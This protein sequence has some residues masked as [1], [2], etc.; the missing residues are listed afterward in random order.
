V[1]QEKP[2]QPPN[3]GNLKTAEWQQLQAQA[4]RLEAAWSTA[5]SVDLAP[6]VPPPGH[7][8]RLVFLHELIKTDLEIRWRRGRGRVL[9][10]YLRKF[11]ELG[12]AANLPASL[13]HEEFR[14][15]QRYDPKVQLTVYQL[16]FP[17]QFND[18]QRLVQQEAGQ[19]TPA[20]VV[21]TPTATPPG[22][23][24][25]SSNDQ[26]VPIGAGYKLVG[27]IGAGGFGEV[28]RAEAPGGFEV[29]LK[30]LFRTIEHEEA[31]REIQ[32]LELI[33]K[34]RHPF[35]LQTQAYWALQDRLYI[36]MELA[37]GSL[38]D[39]LREC[40]AQGLDGIPPDE[41]VQYMKESAEALDFLHARQVMHRDIKPENILLLQRH[42]KLCDFGLARL[43]QS[44]RLVSVT[45]SGTP[46]Y[47][48]PE[49]WANKVCP[50]SDQY[51]LAVTY[52]ELRL[53]RRLFASQ[54][55]VQLMSEVLTRTPSLEPLPQAEQEVLLK[56]MAKD[57]EQRYP[58][59]MAFAE[60]LE[61]AVVPNR[62]P[63]SGDVDLP[64]RQRTPSNEDWEA[65][66]LRSDEV[67]AA[68]SPT[69]PAT[70]S[71][72]PAW[73]TPPA[74]GVNPDRSPHATV[75]RLFWVLIFL[76]L[77][78]VPVL[79]IGQHMFPSGRDEEPSFRLDP[80]PDFPL[81]VGSRGTLT[82][83]I[84]RD[85]FSEPV[86]LTFEGMPATVK[87]HQARIPARGDLV[88][89][90]LSADL[91][92]EP[93]KYLIKVHARGGELKRE[94]AFTLTV[95]GPK[96]WWSDDWRLPAGARVVRDLDRQRL[97]DKIDVIRKV[98]GK[99]VAVRFVLVPRTRA[100]D[101]R[102][103]YIM[104]DKVSV[105]QFRAFATARPKE[106]KDDAWK[107]KDPKEMGNFPQ[108]NL[109]VMQVK[110]L[111]AY[112]F[113][114]WLGGELPSRQ[115][116]DK[117]AGWN[118]P[119]KRIGPFK[120]AWDPK[121]KDRPAVG[122]RG[123]GPLPCGAARQDV[124]PFGCQDMSGNGE[125]WTRDL[126]LFDGVMKDLLKEPETSEAFV[127]TRGRS[128]RAEKPL[129]FEKFDKIKAIRGWQSTRPDLGFRVLIQR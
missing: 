16:R 123:K 77:A 121:A 22:G 41:L 34:L 61:E 76:V 98:G 44:Q 10:F 60:A 23:V 51:C 125:E 109:P 122:R 96:D 116:W 56:A 55:L 53:N 50:Q 75:R 18:V 21:V 106:V 93:R 24:G 3:L 65:G 62:R 8:L 48:A 26:V 2:G 71:G 11:P 105:G 13:I 100:E 5:D 39:R 63:P 78:G 113:A 25:S 101:P 129:I 4:D 43:Q 84:R 20:A 95:E 64:R 83:V 128:W 70:P 112:R 99:V 45:G 59:C 124:S 30:I 14:L 46:A 107:K 66:T 54:N 92:A 35:L 28:Y 94:I 49:M 36:L 118:E 74:L 91:N 72:Q 104:Q 9:E 29:A 80:V 88:R 82:L 120:G 69:Q 127:F 110:V 12:P 42:A 57:P 58:T 7:P 6:F 73:H 108:D 111:D 17:G 102:S 19:K 31:K 86:E 119:G 38:R 68:L 15:R 85:H 97:Y 40:R 103:F 79:L 52:G 27:R 90:E 117:A 114:R 126:S 1:S 81:E 32:A 115:Q 89:V 33:R 47:M 37:D 87:P 67:A